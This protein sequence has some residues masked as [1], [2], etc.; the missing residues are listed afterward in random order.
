MKKIL[1][2]TTG[3]E[4]ATGSLEENLLKHS[5]QDTSYTFSNYLDLQ[6]FIKEKETNVMVDKIDILSFDLV[7]FRKIEGTEQIAKVLAHYLK[8]KNKK[9]IDTSL[10]TT[11][12]GSKLI[13]LMI[14]AINGI[15]VTPTLY[16]H[17][18]QFYQKFSTA[19]KLFGRPLI[20]KATQGRKGKNVFLVSNKHEVEEILVN[21]ESNTNLLYQQYIPNSFDYR[22]LVLGGKSK[23][24]I[25]RTRNS[26]QAIVNN[27]AQGATEEF[28]DPI[29]LPK[30]VL[31]MAEKS[32]NILHREV[33]GVDIIIDKDNNQPYILEV[34]PAPSFTYNM[35]IPIEVKA[36]TD[37]LASC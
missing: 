26:S 3:K 5:R 22:I 25:R 33:A 15:A 10:A 21:T 11:F 16:T 17:K 28:F 13:Q 31:D 7:Y 36:L 32:A 20:V 19:T 2:L 35:E 18:S 1:I 34:N 12:Q 23:V 27:V 9:Y 24:A 29:L 8:S 14:L 37:Y 6:I 4:A 30:A